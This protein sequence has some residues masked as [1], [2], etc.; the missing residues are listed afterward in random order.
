M[1]EDPIP[2]GLE[3][4]TS[5]FLQRLPGLCP[6]ATPTQL[7]EWGQQLS[8]YVSLLYVWSGRTNLV[9]AQDRLRLASRHLLP[10][11]AMRKVIL[12]IPH[13]I[14]A[15]LGSGSGLPG[16]PL[17]IS[18]PGTAFQLIEA[19]R[20]RANF[21]REVTRKLDLNRVE[22]V[23]C[24]VED[25]ECPEAARPDVIVS[26]ATMASE[27]LVRCCAGLLRPRG[28]VLFTL[29]TDATLSA[30]GPDSPRIV[31]TGVP[32]SEG[33]SIRIGVLSLDSTAP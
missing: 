13:Q 21:L 16:V 27:Q 11:L 23:N 7:T 31:D 2:E 6:E 29:P 33:R 17:K 25:W 3:R 1:I 24:R 20:R 26:R 18:L 19:R 30:H 10:S 14:V 32:D 15:D 28:R 5:V 22:V 12:G 8:H 4:D 9:S